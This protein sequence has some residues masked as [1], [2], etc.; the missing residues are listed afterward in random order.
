MVLRN[1]H[2]NFRMI[3]RTTMFWA[4]RL[5]RRPQRL[6]ND[7][8][9]SWAKTLKINYKRSTSQCDQL[10]EFKYHFNTQV[11]HCIDNE[12]ER[13]FTTGDDELIWLIDRRRFLFYADKVEWQRKH[14]INVEMSKEKTKT[15]LETVLSRNG[16]HAHALDHLFSFIFFQIEKWIKYFASTLQ[17]HRVNVQKNPMI[18]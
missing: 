16:N 3:S 8:V 7:S 5:R 4:S 14:H 15:F 6:K 12:N 1:N 11:A 9:E 2:F 17:I 13:L 10:I 18:S